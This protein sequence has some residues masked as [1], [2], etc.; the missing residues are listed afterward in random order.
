[1][2]SVEKAR[3]AGR[4]LSHTYPRA[5][6]TKHD[7]GTVSI[8]S[9]AICHHHSECEEIKRT[10]TR[11][12]QAGLESDHV[13]TELKRYVRPS[14]TMPLATRAGA[15]RTI[16]Q[17]APAP[18]LA[19]YLLCNRSAVTK[20]GCEGRAHVK[21]DAAAS[22]AWA[23]GARPRPADNISDCS[24]EQYPDRVIVDRLSYAFVTLCSLWIRSEDLKGVRVPLS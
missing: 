9:E 12:Q 1:M 5:R 15:R 21:C 10:E 14:S 13:I 6:V 11:A 19:L 16:A 24:G 18:A 20:P 2:L 8:R 22:R 23:G 17:P 4:Q 3:H 7:T